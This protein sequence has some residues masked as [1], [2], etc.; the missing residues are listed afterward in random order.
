MQNA[1]LVFKY[2]LNFYITNP[3]RNSKGNPNP[4]NPTNRNTKYRCEYGSTFSFIHS[5]SERDHFTQSF[6]KP[7]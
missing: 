3:N 5:G 7:S 1:L 4:I 2:V 6:N